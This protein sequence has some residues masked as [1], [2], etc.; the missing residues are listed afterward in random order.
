MRAAIRCGGECGA[1]RGEQ[2]VAVGRAFHHDLSRD[3]AGSPGTDVDDNGLAQRFT[4]F[5]CDGAC[6]QIHRAAGKKSGYKKQPSGFH[7]ECMSGISGP[8]RDSEI[9]SAQAAFARARRMRYSAL[10]PM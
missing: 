8:A 10:F 1:G 5:L 6:M 4:G 7:G 2:G 9:C 3:D